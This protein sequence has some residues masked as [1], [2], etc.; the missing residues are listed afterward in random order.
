MVIIIETFKD[1]KNYEGIYQ[2]SNL[3]NIRNSKGLVLKQR[4]D[5]D[6]Y[7]RIS[8]HKRIG[9][10]KDIK[11]FQV[12]RLIAMSFIENI[13]NF[14]FVNHVDENKENNIVSNLEWCSKKYNNGYGSRNHI[15]K[16]K[17]QR[18]IDITNN[19]L[20]N[21]M[22]EA[23]IPGGVTS[24]AI[25]NVCT[26]RNKSSYGNKFMYYDKYLALQETI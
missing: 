3:G 9:E 18:V 14:Q 22:T 16:S 25:Y 8:L 26:G 15:R 19:I 21:T 24:G 23:G 4:H 7:K 5:K 11:T 20:Y 13:K 2:I 17:I 10:K 6:G 12:H 1:I